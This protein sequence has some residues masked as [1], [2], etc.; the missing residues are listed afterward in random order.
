MQLMVRQIGHSPA[1]G[2]A[3]VIKKIVG[4]I[5]LIDAEDGLQASF[6]KGTVVGYQG[7]A[8]YQGL[9]LLPYLGKDG[10][11]LG[12]F[13]AKAVDLRAP[14]GIVV[15]LGLD[16]GIEL[17]RNLPVPHDDNANGTNAAALVVGCLEIYGCK[18]S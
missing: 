12:V 1:G 13:P 2:P 7:E 17:F 3:S 11:F 9:Y 8:F 18:V 15:R 16:E 5:H 6:V 10:G 14:I 4:I